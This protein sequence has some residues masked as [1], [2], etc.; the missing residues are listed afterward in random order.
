M[1]GGHRAESVRLIARVRYTVKATD[2]VDASVTAAC[3]PRSGSLF[4]VGH[5]TVKCSATE[6][7]ANTAT[8]KFA[9]TVKKRR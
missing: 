2:A 5:T 7:S 4:K 3:K 9:I 6:S 8:A 1:V